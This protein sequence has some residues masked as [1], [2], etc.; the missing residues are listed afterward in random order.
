MAK[1]DSN[2]GTDNTG[3]GNSGDWNS[4]NRNS[5]I[6]NTDEPFMRS[7]NRETTITF[8]D[9]RNSDAYPDFSEMSPCVWVDSSIMTAEEKDANPTHVTTGGYIKK[10]G[11]KEAW[12]IWKRKCSED[13]WKKVLALPNFSA[14][15]FE[16]ITGIKVE[17]SSE[18][19]KKAQELEA[20]AEKLLSKA[21]ELRA[22]L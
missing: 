8:S 2:T 13:N 4:G 10:L 12:A 9:F 3:N 22:S 6:F 18:A 15:I 16:E 11:Y 1:K 19:K 14:E 7:F 20:E 17:D 5:G 21:K